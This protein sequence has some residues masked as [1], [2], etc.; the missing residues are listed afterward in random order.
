[1]HDRPGITDGRWLH[2]GIG[3]QRDAPRS[4]AA[5]DGATRG[6]DSRRSSGKEQT[7]V[8][9]LDKLALSGTQLSE[10]Q[11][12]QTDGGMLCLIL[13]AIFAAGG[14]ALALEYNLGYQ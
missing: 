11:V 14:I 3:H 12:E 5:T 8:S 2:D 7:M 4:T 10:A 6:N 13:L 1:V 9:S